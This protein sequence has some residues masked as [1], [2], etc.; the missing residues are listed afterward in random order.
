MGLAISLESDIS[1]ELARQ[2]ERRTR[3]LGETTAQACVGIAMQ[4]LRSLRAAT[5]KSKGKL[6]PVTERIDDAEL[7]IAVEESKEYVVGFR[8]VGK[9]RKPCI[10]VGNR[11]GAVANDVKPWW[12]VNVNRDVYA[13]KVYRVTLSK[14]R[15]EAWKKQKPTWHMVAKSLDAARLFV[16]QRYQKLVTR[17]SN[18][19]RGTWTRAMSLVADRGQKTDLTPKA[20]AAAMR[21][22]NVAKDVTGFSS[23]NVTVT[24]SNFLPYISKIVGESFVKN[25]LMKALNSTNGMVNSWIRK[26]DEKRW[27]GEI[28]EK[29][30][31]KEV[32]Q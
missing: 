1:D 14:G 26:H 10:R 31:P 28:S 17:Y 24:V 19:G 6:R 8:M 29:P 18:L 11:K 13:A 2:I 9:E 20:G 23:G 16:T 32:F 3:I 5:P 4:T 21:S 12:R 30:F 22:V 7:G 25:A 27:F 15:A